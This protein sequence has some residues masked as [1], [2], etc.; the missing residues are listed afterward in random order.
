MKRIITAALL[1]LSL[2]GCSTLGDMAGLSDTVVKVA[3]TVTDE[4][5]S[6]AK[7]TTAGMSSSDAA[8]VLMNRD[9]YNAVKAVAGAGDKGARSSLVEIESHDGKPI[10]ID[11]KSFKVYAPPQQQAV[12]AG[13]GL[14]RPVTVESN[15]IKWFREIKEAVLGTA[16]VVLPWKMVREQG[17]TIRHESDNNTAARITELG[18]VNNAVTGSQSIAGQA[19]TTFKPATPIIIPAPAAAQAAETPAVTP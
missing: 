9:Y 17:K 8:N 3:E 11:A 2:A 1:A 4:N 16:Q 18:V 19:I 10:V 12:S 15:G 13:L 5:T 6:T 14:Q 7:G